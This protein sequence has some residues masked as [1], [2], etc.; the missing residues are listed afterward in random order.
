M[1][2]YPTPMEAAAANVRRFINDP[3]RANEQRLA[4]ARGAKGRSQSA[5]KHSKK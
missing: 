4:N 2:F 3:R 5:E 1:T